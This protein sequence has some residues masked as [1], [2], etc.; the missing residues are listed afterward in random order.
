MFIL[1]PSC[2]KDKD[3]VKVD[4]EEVKLNLT[5]HIEQ[6]QQQQKRKEQEQAQLNPQAILN[7]INVE[8]VP[9]SE[10]QSSSVPASSSSSPLLSVTQLVS[11]TRGARSH[12]E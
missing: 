9:S 12:P 7:A 1:R 8:Q 5:Y 4:A 3:K 10:A 11:R 6:K 2:N